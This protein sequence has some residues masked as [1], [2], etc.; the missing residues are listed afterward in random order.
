MRNANEN[1]NGMEWNG[2]ESRYER[3]GKL[4]TSEAEEYQL[5]EGQQRSRSQA[6]YCVCFL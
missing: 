3:R 1:V 2:G 6:L 5:Q 4:L